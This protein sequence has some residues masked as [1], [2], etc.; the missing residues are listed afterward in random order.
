MQSQWQVELE[1]GQELGVDYLV[2]VQ[3][4][5]QDQLLVVGKRQGERFGH[6]RLPR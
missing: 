5:D 2:L 4:E 3:F 6:L 1:L